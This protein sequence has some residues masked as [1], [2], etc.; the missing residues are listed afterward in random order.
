MTTLDIPK[1]TV[2]TRNRP[3]IN[4]KFAL[5]TFGS[6]VVAVSLLLGVMI[7]SRRASAQSVCGEHATIVKGLGQLHSERPRAIG[8]STDGSLVEVLVSSSGTWT[9]LVS[10]PHGPTCI[11]ATGDNW[12][13][14]T[15]AAA[16]HAA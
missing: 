1:I 15:V 8:L 6:I 3:G 7:D 10:A 12:E 11:V 9:I 13:S 14:T 2:E 4:G 5:R 16:G